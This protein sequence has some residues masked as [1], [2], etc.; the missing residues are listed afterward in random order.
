[1]LHRDRSERFIGILIEEHPVL[2]T[3]LQASKVAVLTITDL[4]G[5]LRPEAAKRCRNQELR[6]HLDSRNE[7]YGKK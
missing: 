4:A 2:P 3:W 1:M 6:V 7:N 5:R